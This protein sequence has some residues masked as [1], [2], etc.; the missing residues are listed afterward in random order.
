M[1]WHFIPLIFH[2]KHS[3]DKINGDGAAI[4]M[5]E[6]VKIKARPPPHLSSSQDEKEKKEEEVP[7]PKWVPQHT[8]PF[9]QRALKLFNVQCTHRTIF[10]WAHVYLSTRRLIFLN[11]NL[12]KFELHAGY[13][14]PKNSYMHEDNNCSLL[15]MGLPQSLSPPLFPPL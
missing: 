6:G 8:H 5:D 1:L 10:S 15:C 13:M 12:A 3:R 11:T 4:K 2:A 7:T 9:T 14:E